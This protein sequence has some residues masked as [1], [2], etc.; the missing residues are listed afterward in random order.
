MDDGWNSI[1][2][3]GCDW[4]TLLLSSGWCTDPPRET[5]RS[6][7]GIITISYF[8]SDCSTH[9]RLHFQIYADGEKEGV[10]RSHDQRSLYNVDRLTAQPWWDKE[11]TT[12]GPFF[13]LLEANWR[14]IRNEGVALLTLETPEGFANESEKLRDSGD[15]KQFELFAQGRK[16][17]AHCTKV[18]IFCSELPRGA[19][20]NQLTI[21]R[22]R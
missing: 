10:F 13:D 9:Y 18:F 12:Y 4:R 3:R 6:P 22:L 8:I 16:N 5:R 15:W 2:R 1:T 21:Y 7:T 17:A 19:R 14:Q 20:D 11:A